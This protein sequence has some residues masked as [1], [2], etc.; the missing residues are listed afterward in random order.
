ML[1][2]AEQGY[3]KFGNAYFSKDIIILKF[4]ELKL[5]ATF[6]RQFAKCGKWQ[7]GWTTPI[8]RICHLQ[9][10]TPQENTDKINIYKDL[11]K[12]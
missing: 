4:L 6:K 1:F 8:Y 7:M 10:L 11:I 2:L 5:F 9:T 12:I 3:F